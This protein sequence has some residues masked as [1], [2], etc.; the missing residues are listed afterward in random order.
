MHRVHGAQLIASQGCTWLDESTLNPNVLLNGLGNKTFVCGEPPQTSISARAQQID[1]SMLV[2]VTAKVNVVIG[3][4][5]MSPASVRECVRVFIIQSS[6]NWITHI[7]LF[8]ISY[9]I[10]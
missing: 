7:F 10:Q 5:C 9:Y 4:S 6:R 3:D 8:I 2:H 1:H